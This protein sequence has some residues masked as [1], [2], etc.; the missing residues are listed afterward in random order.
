MLRFPSSGSRVRIP[1]AA[2]QKAGSSTRGY[3]PSCFRGSEHLAARVQ[4]TGSALCRPCPSPA[5]AA[6]SCL[7]GPLRALQGTEG[8]PVD[9][10]A[11]IARLHLGVP[12]QGEVRVRVT[13]NS[14]NSGRA[15]PVRWTPSAPLQRELRSD[16]DDRM[17]PG[18]G[19]VTL[20]VIPQCAY[21]LH[22]SSRS[23]SSWARS[24]EPSQAQ[25]ESG[26][27]APSP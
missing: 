10:L 22:W 6:P 27:S 21:L 8:Q 26:A 1:S 15:G 19:R 16:R 12:P 5:A 3:R 23:L 20:E 25:P 14:G 4:Q 7:P 9:L 13:E 2:Q 24:R 11:Q 18:S 17:P